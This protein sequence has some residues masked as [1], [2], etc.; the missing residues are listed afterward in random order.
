VVQQ[1][2][3]ARQR[4][5]ADL[6]QGPATHRALHAAAGQCLDD[7][8]DGHRGTQQG[9]R[10]RRRR[11]DVALGVLERVEQRRD[12]RGRGHVAERRRRRGALPRAAQPQ[13]LLLLA[14]VAAGLEVARDVLTRLAR[15]LARVAREH[16]GEDLR[17]AAVKLGEG[18]VVA[19]DQRERD[20]AQVLLD[21]LAPALLARQHH[22][23]QDEHE[24]EGSGRQRESQRRELER[25]D[26]QVG[27]VP[28]S[29]G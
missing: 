28:G 14:D 29:P 20:V 18:D 13:Q 10:S 19:V 17:L 6:H 24:D 12:R 1:A 5:R 9:Q 3:Q 2:A 7:R 21:G 8:L 15:Q 23:S 4:G 25:L 16:A 22:P 27:G 26:H 11:P